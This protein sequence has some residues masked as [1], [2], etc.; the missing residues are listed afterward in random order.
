[1]QLR[2]FVLFFAL[3]TIKTTLGNACGAR[4]CG[5]VLRGVNLFELLCIE[6][7]SLTRL[8]QLTAVSRYIQIAKIV[9]WKTIPLL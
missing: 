8:W 3:F 1:M 9:R 6:I 7:E 5:S 2:I 4:E